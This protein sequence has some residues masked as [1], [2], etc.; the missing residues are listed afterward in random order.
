MPGIGQDGRGQ[1]A[2]VIGHIT[3]VGTAAR[4]A[5]ISASCRVASVVSAGE[6]PAQT[7]SSRNRVRRGWRLSVN[8]QL[9]GMIRAG[10]RPSTA[11]PANDTAWPAS[12]RTRL[13]STSGWECG[14]DYSLCWHA[15]RR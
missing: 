1:P 9:A 13:I 6:R 2:G 15:R 8:R 11:M 14:N 10:L 12:P 3:L 4:A 5:L 7:G